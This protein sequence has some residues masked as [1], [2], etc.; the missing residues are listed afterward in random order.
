MHPGGFTSAVREHTLWR[1]T[2]KGGQ[3]CSV[4]DIQDERLNFEVGLERKETNSR[5]VRNT[6]VRLTRHAADA[7][8]K[9]QLLHGV[10]SQGDNEADNGNRGPP[11][12]SRP[13]PPGP[14]R[15]NVL[16]PDDGVGLAFD[17]RQRSGRKE[18]GRGGE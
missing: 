6:Q 4:A 16:A 14:F 3:P 13:A 8:V 10:P 12:R 1:A 9:T 17:L 2:V 15:G 18:G 11:G 5:A 7:P